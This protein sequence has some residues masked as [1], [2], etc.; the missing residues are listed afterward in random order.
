MKFEYLNGES[1]AIK[2]NVQLFFY[3][4]IQYFMEAN[5]YANITGVIELIN[6]F[7]KIYKKKFFVEGKFK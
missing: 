7:L 4:I 2:R 1:E 5:Q 3:Y 6:Y